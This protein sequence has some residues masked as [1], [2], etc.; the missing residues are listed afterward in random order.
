MV[1]WIKFFL[2]LS[3]GLLVELIW[4]AAIGRWMGPPNLTH[5]VAMGVAMNA[6]PRRGALTGGI[7][8]LLND[9]LSVHPDGVETFAGLL[10]GALA[11]WGGRRIL[12]ETELSRFVAVGFLIVAISAMVSLANFGLVAARESALIAQGYSIILRAQPQ[13]DYHGVILAIFAWPL[14]ARFIESIHLLDEE[15]GLPTAATRQTGRPIK[16]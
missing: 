7:A 14:L 9:L 15:E 11:G 4:D 13:F 2:F 10:I 5:L 16:R 3:I 8:G 1:S 12:L 6:G